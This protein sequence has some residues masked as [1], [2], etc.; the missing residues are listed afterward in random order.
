MKL[1]CSN[2]YHG[3]GI[4]GAENDKPAVHVAE[5]I[6]ALCLYRFVAVEYVIVFN[7]GSHDR[8]KSAALVYI[9]KGF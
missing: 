2:S 3:K 5:L 7:S 8:L 9:R 6:H 1:C 4:V